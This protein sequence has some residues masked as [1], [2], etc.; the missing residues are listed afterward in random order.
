MLTK[1][2]YQILTLGLFFLSMPFTSTFA[3]TTQLDKVVAIVNNSALTQSQLN[4]TMQIIT[5]Q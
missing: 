1:K 2:S 4:D 3:N 5:Q